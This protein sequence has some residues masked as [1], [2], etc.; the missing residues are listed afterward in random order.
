MK[1]FRLVGLLSQIFYLKNPGQENIFFVEYSSANSSSFVDGPK[2]AKISII[3]YDSVVSRYLSNI[4]CAEY[5]H[6]GLELYNI[7]FL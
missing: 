5:L 1:F 3:N 6:K 2:D 7:T 4:C